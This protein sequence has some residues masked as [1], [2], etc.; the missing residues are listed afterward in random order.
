[1]M[2][3]IMSQMELLVR[4]ATASDDAA[5]L[6]YESAKPYYDAYA[7][8]EARARALLDTVWGHG[9]HAASWEVCSVA[10]VDGSVVGVL[11]GYPATEGDRYARR[12]LALTMRRMPPWRW[13][14]VLSHLRAAQ[15]ISPSPPPRTWYIDAL[16][17]APPWRRHGVARRLLAE[18]DRRATAAG[19]AGVAL[20]TGL[21]NAP[22]RSLYEATGFTLEE[23]REAPDERLARAVGGRGFA[24]YFRPVQPSA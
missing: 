8:E 1:M 24:A 7:G 9:G 15:R 2:P 17:V 6:L 20:D 5:G 14:A 3:A 11:A 4:P 16:A 18:A 13:P 21:E 19:L 23:I 22:A 10:E 12:F